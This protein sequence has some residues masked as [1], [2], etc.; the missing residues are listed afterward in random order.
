[1]RPDPGDSRGGHLTASAHLL[2]LI[3]ARLWRAD[4]GF[5]NEIPR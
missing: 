3:S 1:M 2:I 5:P 4:A